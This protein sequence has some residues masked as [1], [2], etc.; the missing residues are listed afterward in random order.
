MNIRKKSHIK[1]Y[2][3]P[4]DYDEAPLFD[5]CENLYNVV[6]AES[7][8]FGEEKSKNNEKQ[9]NNEKT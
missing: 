1:N 7:D 6:E 3:K 2:N 5:P 4:W 9:R 8:D